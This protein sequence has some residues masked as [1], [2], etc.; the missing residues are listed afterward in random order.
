MVWHLQYRQRI[1]RHWGGEI[2]SVKEGFFPLIKTRN[3]YDNEAGRMK[4]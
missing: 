3:P 1:I 4:N 2:L